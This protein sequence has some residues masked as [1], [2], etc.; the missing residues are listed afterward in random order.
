MQTRTVPRALLLSLF[1]AAV[2]LFASAPAQAQYGPQSHVGLMSGYGWGSGPAADQSALDTQ[3]TLDTRAIPWGMV[4]NLGGDSDKDGFGWG[5][6]FSGTLGG[7][8]QKFRRS[9]LGPGSSNTDGVWTSDFDL[10][11]DLR[12]GLSLSY[13]SS[14]SQLLVR[15]RYFNWYNAGGLRAFHGNSDDPASLGLGVAW[16]KLG[17]DVDYGT[18][19]IPG[20]LVEAR[21][22]SLLRVEGRY[23]LAI[24]DDGQMVWLGGLRYEGGFLQRSATANGSPDTTASTVIVFISM[25]FNK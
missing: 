23:K 18:D 6:F 16:R 2:A 1:F 24:W 11:G 5:G 21:D 17:L 12:L 4:F 9:G 7:S 8:T 25:A 22:W 10:M 3:G 14:A 15:L 20:L 19:G 13:R